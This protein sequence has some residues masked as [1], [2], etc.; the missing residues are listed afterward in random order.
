MPVLAARN[1]SFILRGR[2]HKE[3]LWRLQSSPL[4]HCTVVPEVSFAQTNIP[5]DAQLMNY[6][7]IYTRMIINDVST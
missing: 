2:L 6:R 7:G 4:Y 3:F 5:D 1:S